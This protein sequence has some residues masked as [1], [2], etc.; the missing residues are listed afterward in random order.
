MASFL[1]CSERNPRLGF[2]VLFCTA[3]VTHSIAPGR[4]V[5]AWFQGPSVDG[6]LGGPLNP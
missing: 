2:A 5:E 3:T 1:F 4:F 6:T